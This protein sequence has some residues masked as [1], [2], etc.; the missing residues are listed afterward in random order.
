MNKKILYLDMDGVVADFEKGIGELSPDL[1]NFE[2]FEDQELLS[3][4]IDQICFANPKIYND[5]PPIEGA[6]AAVEKLSGLYDIYFLST[7]M[8][9]LPQS[10][11]GKR[12]W[13]AQHFE[14]IGRKRLILTHRKDLLL[15]DF[16]VDDRLK[17]GAAEFRGEHIHFG[18]EKFPDWKVTS[19]YLI[20]RS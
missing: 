4:K 10:F 7:A 20:S 5:L 2:S 18:T 8:W 14:I 15:G 11:T 17:N 13:I 1:K 9:S 6:I 19:D 12:I 16:L 3:D